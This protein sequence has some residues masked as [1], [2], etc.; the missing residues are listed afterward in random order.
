MHQVDVPCRRQT[1]T[2]RKHALFE[3]TDAMQTLRNVHEGYL[4]ARFLH[5]Q[6]REGVHVRLVER[7]PVVDDAYSS[8]RSESKGMVVKLVVALGTD[9]VVGE[10]KVQLKGHFRDRHLGDEGFDESG[11]VG[12]DG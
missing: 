4:E 3:A 9:R 7:V 8:G 6:G 11:F 10:E 1:D 2:L 5:V 12:V